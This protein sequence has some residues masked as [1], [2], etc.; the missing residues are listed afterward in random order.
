MAALQGAATAV[1]G[2]RP[3]PPQLLMRTLYELSG[4]LLA[5]TRG[6]ACVGGET[7]NL[8][9]RARHLARMHMPARQNI[10]TNLG[11]RRSSFLLAG[12][13]PTSDTGGKADLS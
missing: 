6:P 4:A 9:Q 12:K 2:M 13:N 3:C 7:V 10:E 11:R 8:G 1:D 5:W